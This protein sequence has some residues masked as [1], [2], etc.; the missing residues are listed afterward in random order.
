MAMTDRTNRQ[1]PLDS[2]ADR[3]SVEAEISGDAREQLLKRDPHSD[4]DI[5]PADQFVQPG[6]HEFPIEPP[7]RP[8]PPHRHG[9]L[10][11]PL[12]PTLRMAA[13]AGIAIVVLLAVLAAV[14]ILSF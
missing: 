12:P 11:L 6:Q 7:P 1:P 10:S 4:T 8:R 2:E 9:W 3:V 14:Y 5:L 13:L